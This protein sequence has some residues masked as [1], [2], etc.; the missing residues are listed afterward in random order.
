MEGI[1]EEIRDR[2]EGSGQQ[3][4]IGQQDQSK[5]QF[6]QSSEKSEEGQSDTGQSDLSIQSE[7]AL[8]G[9]SDQQDLAQ[10]QSGSA[11]GATG[12]QSQDGFVASQDQDSGDYL[13]QG[14]SPESGFAEQG[15]GASN[16][17]GDIEGTSERS[18]NR[19]SD[20]EGSSDNN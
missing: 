15:Q 5:Q 14:G 19:E 12:Q 10:D 6:S 18:Q 20:I 13:Q 9:R 2:N 16:D 8:A 1:R 7:T 17:S 11:G 3:Q 4:P